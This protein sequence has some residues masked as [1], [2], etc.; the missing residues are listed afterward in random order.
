M[1]KAATSLSK[2]ADTAREELPST[3]AA[4]RLS[5]MEI[6]DLT[7]E[8]SDLRDTIARFLKFEGQLQANLKPFLG[9]N[10]KEPNWSFR[11]SKARDWLRKGKPHSDWADLGPGK[12]TGP[13]SAQQGEERR[14]TWYWRSCGGGGSVL[15]S[16]TTASLS[17]VTGPLSTYKQKGNGVPP[18]VRLQSRNGWS[19][20]LAF[21][22]GGGDEEREGDPKMGYNS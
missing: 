15:A 17:S 20:I 13:S 19:A 3:M 7:L 11:D 6:S 18:L 12:V 21:G 4:I 5:G 1:G 9:P 16:R 8:L 22:G 14:R 10:G 2:L